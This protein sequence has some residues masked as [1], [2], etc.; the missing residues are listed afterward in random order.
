MRQETDPNAARID[1]PS[2]RLFDPLPGQGGLFFS[3]TGRHA[4]PFRHCLSDH[5]LFDLP[6]LSVLAE[7]LAKHD[8]V[9]WSACPVGVSDRWEAGTKDRP[10]L[11][12]TIEDI[13][14]GS[15]LVMLKSVVHDAIFGP[16]IR[17]T[18]E[19][20]IAL[21]GPPL[22]DDVV[23]ARA[24]I[25]IAS[26]RRITAYHIDSDLN[27][28]MQVSGKKLFRV[29][30]RSDGSLITDEELERYFGGD[31]NGAVYREARSNDATVFA[32]DAGNGVHVPPMSPH[33]AQNG[34]DVSIAVS[35]NFDL[36]S[37]ER[38]ARIH[39]V[40]RRLR[41]LGWRPLAPGASRVADRTKL[42]LYRLYAAQ[43][44]WGRRPVGSDGSAWQP[45]RS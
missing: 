18:L 7:R 34:D 10:P 26:P 40:N 20:I 24:T 16:V 45:P 5:P 3:S 33:W 25:L 11:M 42:A 44:W 4:F 31:A 13:R 22:Q 28:L 27:F 38:V 12:A 30:D 29:Y 23:G 6:H 43:G 19:R 14:H 2:M 21:A 17:H 41:H 37:I 8:A 1:D 9:Y 36:R 39:K 35:F 15:S 32:L